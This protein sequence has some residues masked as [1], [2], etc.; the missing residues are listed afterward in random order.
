MNLKQ[1]ARTKIRETCIRAQR[2][3]KIFTNPVITSWNLL[4]DTIFDYLENLLLSST[5]CA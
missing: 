2:S 1:R 3:L 4:A 5:K